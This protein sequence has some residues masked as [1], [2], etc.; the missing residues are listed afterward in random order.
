VLSKL[1]NTVKEQNVLVCGGSLVYYKNNVIFP[2]PPD[3]QKAIFKNNELM[4]FSDY[5]FDFY[6]QRFIYST[7][8]LRDNDLY[9]PEYRC[10]EDP[11]FFIAFMTK[12]K[13]FYAIKDEVYCYRSMP[14]QNTFTP[15]QTVDM[16]KGVQNCL[17]LAKKNGY[18]ILY[19]TSIKR[20]NGS[21]FIGILKNNIQNIAIKKE[22]KNILSAIDDSYKNQLNVFFHKYLQFSPLHSKISLIIPVYNVEKYIRKCLDS[23]ISQTLKDIEIICVNDGSTDDSLNIL[24]EYE[25]KDKRIIVI[26]Q[27][28]SGLGAARNTGLDIARAP[29]IMFIDSDDWIDFDT[30]EIYHKTATK[31]NVCIVMSNFISVPED[32]ASLKRC[33]MFTKYYSSLEKAEGKYEF[34]GNFREYRVSACCK[35]FKKEIIDKHNL[36]FPV[37]LINEDEAWHWYY[38]SHVKSIYYFKKAYYNRLVRNDSIMSNREIRKHGVLDLLYILEHIYNYLQKNKLYE[39]YSEQYSK[40]FSDVVSGVLKRCSGNNELT[41][42]ANTKIQS[43]REMII[44]SNAMIA[45]NINMLSTIKDI[46][47]NNVLINTQFEYNLRIWDNKVVVIDILNMKIAYDIVPSENNVTVSVVLRKDC[48][49]D[50]INRIYPLFPKDRNKKTIFIT[51]ILKIQTLLVDFMIKEIDI[52]MNKWL[53]VNQV[54]SA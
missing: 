52:V 40:Y 38:F 49:K 14:K 6:Y 8:V 31:E 5:Q 24:R 16:L 43:L 28:N 54:Q 18:N 41:T 13:T 29:Y 21:Y 53:L 42:Q 50:I 23:A 33:D 12:A 7:K 36:R 32:D 35:L 9:F 11:P 26:D 25:K 19:D 1:Y 22:I 46:L 4:L 39:K 3:L 30:L 27:K 2:L 34:I 17:L 45:D 20:I 10:Y 51:S 37:N 15:I 44:L 48:D 47:K